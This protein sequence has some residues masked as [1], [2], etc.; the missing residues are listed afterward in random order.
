[1][2]TVA[3]TTLDTTPFKI[4]SITKI[5]KIHL[6]LGLKYVNILYSVINVMTFNR[7]KSIYFFKKSVQSTVNYNR[8]H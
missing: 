2:G 4:G 3:F 5:Q 8:T 6:K 7:G 1:M